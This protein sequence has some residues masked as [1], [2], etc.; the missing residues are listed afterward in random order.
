M[1]LWHVFV[2]Q[3]VAHIV[4]AQTPT[5]IQHKFWHTHA[6]TYEYAIG[7]KYLDEVHAP[8]VGLN[9]AANIRVTSTNFKVNCI[10]SRTFWLILSNC[11]LHCMKKQQKF[12]YSPIGNLQYESVYDYHIYLPVLL[13]LYCTVNS[14][15]DL[16]LSH[17]LVTLTF[18]HSL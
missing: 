17:I 2:P 16:L 4:N 13:Q 15:T 12:K 6:H 9:F 3:T 11:S 8:R 18:P 7:W 14:V 5:C 10:F 1:H